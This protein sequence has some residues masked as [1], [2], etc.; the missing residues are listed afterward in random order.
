MIA[1]IQRSPLQEFA[2]AAEED[3]VDVEP[4]TASVPFGPTEPTAPDCD[5]VSGPGAPGRVGVPVSNCRPVAVAAV[6]GPVIGPGPC[7]PLAV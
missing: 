1:G 5:K 4:A 2:I 7:G 6:A 3:G